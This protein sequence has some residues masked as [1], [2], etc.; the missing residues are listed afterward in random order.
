MCQYRHKERH[1]P[2]ALEG[3]TQTTP[4]RFGGVQRTTNKRPAR[5]VTFGTMFGRENPGPGPPRKNWAQWCS[6]RGRLRR[7]GSGTG[8]SW[9]RRNVSRRGDTRSK[10]R[11]AGFA[12]QLK[13][14]RAATRKTGG[15]EGG[16][17]IETAVDEC[18]KQMVTWCLGTG[19]TTYPSNCSRL[20]VSCS[21]IQLGAV[22]GGG[23]RQKKQYGHVTPQ[24]TK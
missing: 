1:N 10:R 13:T 7:A 8:G 5:Q 19:F 9:K 14:P 21:V 18:R 17:R 24:L 15:R 6:G 23:A 22:I 11:E 3:P 2:K 4:L 20:S 12:T 16:N